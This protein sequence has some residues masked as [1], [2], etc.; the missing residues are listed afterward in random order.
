MLTS[1]V[2]MKN[3]L[4]FFPEGYQEIEYYQSFPDKKIRQILRKH[5][6]WEVKYA[7]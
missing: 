6:K 2:I 4:K 7:Y 3:R 5:K 1:Q